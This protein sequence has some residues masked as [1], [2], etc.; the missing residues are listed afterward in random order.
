MLILFH[1]YGAFLFL[2]FDVHELT[3][4]YSWGAYLFSVYISWDSV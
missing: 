3:K 4:Y 2:S 1:V